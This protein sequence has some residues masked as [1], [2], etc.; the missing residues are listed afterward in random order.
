[1]EVRRRNASRARQMIDPQTY[2]MQV[3]VAYSEGLITHTELM[4]LATIRLV[5]DNGFSYTAAKWER[6][7]TR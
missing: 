4:Q 7:N 5:V 6:E 1:M 3:I 2:I